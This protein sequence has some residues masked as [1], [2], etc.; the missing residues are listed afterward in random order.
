[1]DNKKPSVSVIMSTHNRADNFLPKA[2]ES[3]IKQTYKDWELII[4]D[5]CSTDNT[6]EVVL[7]YKEKDPRIRYIRL[8]KNFGNDTKPKNIG[9]K[10]AKG[11]YLSFIDDDC[12][13]RTEHLALLHLTL[14]KNP[15]LAFVYG[16][17]YCI[18]TPEMMK[19]VEEGGEGL[20][21]G[22]GTYSDFDPFLLMKKNYIDTSDVMC[23]T[24]DVVEIG[25]YDEK[26]RKFIDWNLWVRLAKTGKL[27]MRVPQMIT[28]YYLHDQMKTVLNKE[29]QFNPQTGLFTPT[30]DTINCKIHS[31]C[32]GKPKRP[33]I[34]VFTLLFNR[35]E[36]TK[37]MLQSILDT[38]KIPIDK[39]VF[40][41][42]GSN[43][44]TVDYMIEFCKTHNIPLDFKKG[45]GEVT[46]P[47]SYIGDAKLNTTPF[48]SITIILNIENTGI[49]FASNQALDVIEPR[50]VD[51]IMK[52]DNDAL[53]LTKGFLEAMMDIYSRNEMMC[54]SPYIEGL[55][56][57]PGAMPRMAYG[58]IGDEYLGMVSHLGGICTMAPAKVYWN[59]RWPNSFM[60][61]GNDVLFSSYVQKC[62][63]QLAFTENYRVEHYKS[64]VKQEEDYP[65][66][67]ADKEFLR[68]TRYTPKQ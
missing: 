20:K 16:D 35:I 44:G 64:T 55:F 2:I 45:E 46:L 12:Q 48:K 23:R 63:Y 29:G 41:D 65:Q 7:S 19:P 38:T 59:W 11:E 17:R 52:C 57:M 3:V 43:D 27:F 13:Y 37:V 26:I 33:K 28:D 58:T 49:P 1:M 4:V 56:S 22:V 18:P 61:G 5:D 39:W 21:P 30:F 53:Y 9:I 60:Q 15:G 47:N 25:G 51:Y 31:G 40:V 10:H 42:Q 68:R 32:I 67:Y 14:S 50:T 6:K 54:L 8:K 36:Y 34:A 24:K 62:G 66:Y